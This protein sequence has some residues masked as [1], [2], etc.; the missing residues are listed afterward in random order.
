METTCQLAPGDRLTFV[1]D[2]V[3]EATSPSG[4]LYGFERT[5]AISI[6]PANAIAEAATR[7]GQEDDITVLIVT[8]TV[9]LNPMLA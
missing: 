2:G 5:R 1:S 7:F 9:G 6:Q 8:R 3:L 4:E